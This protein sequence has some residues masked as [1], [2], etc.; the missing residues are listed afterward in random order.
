MNI[1]MSI[2]THRCIIPLLSLFPFYLLDLSKQKFEFNVVILLP[3]IL[4]FGNIYMILNCFHFLFISKTYLPSQNQIE[5]N[6]QLPLIGN[7]RNLSIV[8]E[9]RLLASS[10]G[11]LPSLRVYFP[12]QVGSFFVHN[13]SF[14][15]PFLTTITSLLPS[16]LA[17]NYFY[18]SL[19]LF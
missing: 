11:L 3:A 8:K 10:Q 15:F 19:L 14:F 2:L 5:A 6:N 13:K 4:N 12:F 1:I 16:S 9:R 18:L 17:I 7:E